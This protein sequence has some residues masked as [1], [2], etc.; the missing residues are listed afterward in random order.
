M[1]IVGRNGV[2][3]K[4]AWSDGVKTYLGMQTAGFPNFFMLV[5]PQ[6]GATFCNIPRCS[7]VFI[8]WLDTLFA[9]IRD[10]GAQM[11]EPTEEAQLEYTELCH[12]LLDL[13]LIGTTNS[14][15]TGINKNL[16]GRQKRDVLLW[17]GG[18]PSYR[19]LIAD[20]AAKNYEGFVIA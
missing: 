12:K 13:I 8:D 14:W 15:F 9:R 6:S 11:I 16:D 20:V 17:A 18:N 2:S 3:L 10:Q 4:N 1:D 7:A 19:D 5:G